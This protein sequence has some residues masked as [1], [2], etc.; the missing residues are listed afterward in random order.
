MRLSYTHKNEIRTSKTIKPEP[1][2]FLYFPPLRKVHAVYDLN[3][4]GQYHH[5]PVLVIWLLLQEIFVNCF[6]NFLTTVACY[7]VTVTLLCMST[8]SFTLA[9]IIIS[10]KIVQ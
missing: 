1:T 5:Y 3:A 2:D 6:C 9:S 7:L 10:E 8:T 4:L